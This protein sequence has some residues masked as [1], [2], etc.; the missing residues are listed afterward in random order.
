MFNDLI[1]TNRRVETLPKTM[2]EV[3]D[4]R[5]CDLSINNIVDVIA[6]KDMQ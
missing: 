4:V 1:I 6:L 5:K 2:E 3:K